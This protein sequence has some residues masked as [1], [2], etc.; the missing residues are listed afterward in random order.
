[1]KTFATKDSNGNYHPCKCI[2][3]ALH[4]S[5]FEVVEIFEL[6]VKRM[7]L[8][9]EGRSVEGPLPE[10]HPRVNLNDVVEEGKD[11]GKQVD[12]FAPKPI[13]KPAGFA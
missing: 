11:F 8:Y 10:E 7:G 1:M 6:E 5:D 9:R 2:A 3:S 13:N 12:D 4:E